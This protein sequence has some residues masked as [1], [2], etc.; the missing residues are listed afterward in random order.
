MSHV[1]PEGQAVTRT[2]GYS[3]RLLFSETGLRTL[4][5]LPNPLFAH[6]PHPAS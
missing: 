3:S 4:L 2:Q 6:I 5:G 1:R